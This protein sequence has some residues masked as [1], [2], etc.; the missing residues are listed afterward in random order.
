MQKGQVFGC[1][2]GGDGQALL[3]TC[4]DREVLAAQ[5]LPAAR[6]AR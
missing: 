1:A 5:V 2:T 4:A 6:G 3:R